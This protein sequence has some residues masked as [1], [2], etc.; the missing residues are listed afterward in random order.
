MR[1]NRMKP[2]LRK[3]FPSS[4]YQMSFIHMTMFTSES[5]FPHSYRSASTGRVSA[6]RI[7]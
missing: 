1:E 3:Y 5:P 2:Q 6:T 7:T 4:K